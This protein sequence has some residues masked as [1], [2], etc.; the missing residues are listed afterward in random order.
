MLSKIQS[1]FI[2]LKCIRE[3]NIQKQQIISTHLQ[4]CIND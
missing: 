3:E 1:K 4:E 2:R